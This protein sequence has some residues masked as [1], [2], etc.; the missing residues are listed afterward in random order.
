MQQ[1]NTKFYRY[2]CALE[3]AMVAPAHSQHQEKA[4][5]IVAFETGAWY[6]NPKFRE[7]RYQWAN[8]YISLFC[9][10]LQIK[11]KCKACQDN[12]RRQISG[13]S[14]ITSQEAKIHKETHVQ[15]N[16]RIEIS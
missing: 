13:L 11:T 3:S 4:L 6:F 12:Q 8:K 1:M 7:K 14:N 16:Q 5:K 2:Q 15:Q 10:V 9:I